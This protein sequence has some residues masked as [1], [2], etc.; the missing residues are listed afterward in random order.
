MSSQSIVRGLA[1]ALLISF[2]TAPLCAQSSVGSWHSGVGGWNGA[3][4]GAWHAGGFGPANGNLGLVVRQTDDVHNQV[5]NL[6][7]QLRRLQGQQAV[8]STPFQTINDSFFERIGVN[9]GFNISGGKHVVG[10]DA[11]G[12][13]TQSGAIEFRQGSFDSAIPQFGGFDPASQSTFGFGLNNGGSGF[14]LQFAGGQGSNRSIVTQTPMVSLMD[15]QP[16]GFSD[17]SQRPFVTSVIPVVG[18]NF[19]RPG[20]PT[21]PS[22]NSTLRNTIQQYRNQEAMLKASRKRRVDKG[23]PGPKPLTVADLHPEDKIPLQL[24]SSRASSAGHGD[25]SVAEIRARKAARDEAK[26]AGENE[27]LLALI[28]RA[29]GAE[30][31]GKSGVAKIYY[32]QAARR[33]TGE[34]K[35][36]L[37]DKIQSF[38]SP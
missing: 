3:P 31:R 37:L 22:V 26:D 6:L 21:G 5:G 11:A 33:A 7:E 24:A 35:Q 36:E 12:N 27:E 13:P 29:R 34:K 14:G 23:K 19:P 10:L 25:L 17:V 28:E 1:A 32:Q 4:G 2:S 18:A 15:G 9:F 16:G 20:L 38:S 30:A 8:V